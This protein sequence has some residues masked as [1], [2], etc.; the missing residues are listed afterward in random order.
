[1]FKPRVRL[2]FN[3]D[4][5]L[6]FQI[7]RIVGVSVGFLV[8]ATTVVFLFLFFFIFL[9]FFITFLPKFEKDDL[10]HELIYNVYKYL[11][12]VSDYSQLNELR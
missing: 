12:F 3:F 6:W 8:G 4:V 11:M 2:N 1:M 5:E 10:Q 7:V 9:L